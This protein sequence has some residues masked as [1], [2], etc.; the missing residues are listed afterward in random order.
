MNTLLIQQESYSIFIFKC[1]HLYIYAYMNS[2]NIYIIVKFNLLD[3]NLH[4]LQ[5][6]PH[7]DYYVNYNTKLLKLK[8]TNTFLKRNIIFMKYKLQNT[9]FSVLIIKL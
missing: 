9:M 2:I 7:Y 3:E 4:N 5:Y 1:D 6:F 8:I